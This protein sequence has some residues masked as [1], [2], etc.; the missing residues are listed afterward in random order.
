MIFHGLSVARN[1]LRP[2]TASLDT[3]AIKIGLLC[4]FTKHFKGLFLLDKAGW[5]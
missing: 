5:V 1:G 3:L 2:G 4:N